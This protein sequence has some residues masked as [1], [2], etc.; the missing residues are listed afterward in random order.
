MHGRGQDGFT[1]VELVVVVALV[2]LVAASAGTFF[3]GGASPAVATASRDLTAALDEARATASAFDA[4]SVVVTPALA[5]SGYRARVYQRFP[6][7]PSFAPRNGPTYESTV[8][9]AETAAPL[10]AP[11]FAL[12]FDAHGAVLG[13]TN[14]VGAGTTSAASRPCPSAGAF[15]LQLRYERDAQQLTI[16]C[17]LGPSGAAPVLWATPPPAAAPS[18]VGTGT[19]PGDQTCT[20]AVVTPAPGGGSCPPG[21]TPDPSSP[22]LCDPTPLPSSGP[23]AGPAPTCPPG[24]SGTFPN[25]APNAAPTPSSVPACVAGA[26]DGLGFATCLEANPIVPTGPAITRSGCGTHTPIGDP[27]PAF[28]VAV[29]VVQNGAL[30]GVYD[31]QL[32]T[33]KG[34]WLDLQGLPPAQTCGLLYT[35]SFTIAAIVP[36]SGNARDNP[37]LDT[38]DPNLAGAGVGAITVPPP[39]AAWGSND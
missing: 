15:V 19:C 10:G 24:S 14:L 18:P 7:D 22:G 8:S 11:G 16:P 17:R 33:R 23:S 5:G 35:L 31:V 21:Y 39:G 6:G 36:V 27:G 38:G 28:T 30:W 13:W 1:L 29:D 3:L 20:L 25:C 12:T 32:A 37:A 26:P 9:I 34:P 4:A 2:A